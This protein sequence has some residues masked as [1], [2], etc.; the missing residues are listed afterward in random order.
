MSNV[1][2]FPN[3]RIARVDLLARA[4]ADDRGPRELITLSAEYGSVCV[5]VAE[6]ELWLTPEEAISLAC[7]L[8]ES[9]EDAEAMR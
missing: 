1:I 3:Q 5:R 4:I 8:H 2:P 7:D 9:A 6:L